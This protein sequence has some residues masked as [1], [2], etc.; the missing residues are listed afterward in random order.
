MTGLDTY[1]I[2]GAF[3]AKTTYMPSFIDAVGE[4]VNRAACVVL[5][6]FAARLEVLN[7]VLDPLATSP[8]YNG[9][10]ATYA[11]RCGLPLPDG[12][13]GTPGFTGGQCIGTSYTITYDYE[14]STNRFTEPPGTYTPQSGSLVRNGAITSLTEENQV[15]AAGFRLVTSAGSEFIGVASSGFPNNVGV[16]NLT[17]IQV[18]P[19]F[20][21]PD[22]CGNP[23]VTP[24]VYT[25]GSNTYNTNVTYNDN[26]GTEIT[27]P[28][29]IAL[30][31]ATFNAN[32]EV[33]I[34]VN[35]DFE[36]NPE[37]NFNAEFNFNTGEVT[38]DL[39]NPSAPRPPSCTD[40]NGF[41]PDPTIPAPPPEIPDSG[42]PDTPPDEPTERE[43]IINAAI[44]TVSSPSDN[45]SVIFQEENPDIY[46]PALGYVQ[47]K[48]RVG[49]SSAWTGDIPIKCKR[50]FVVC[51]WPLGAVDVRGTGR[52]GNAITVTP[53]KSKVQLINP[54][55]D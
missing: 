24:P 53:I 39:R 22:N 52:Y 32:A 36:L 40:P 12:F 18:T 27:I 3:L 16:R 35:L 49:A 26:E 29:V 34:P 21:Q 38:P 20:G 15:N 14:L 7:Y 17:N 25:P 30:G 51:P 4:S 43:E 6:D 10:A 41:E 37:L 13:N 9:A 54:F 44:V 1:A 11:A 48:I 8:S 19:N 55:P 46:V 47:F 31:Y 33:T 2:L 50:Q 42:S 5:G 28:V 23:P 45:E